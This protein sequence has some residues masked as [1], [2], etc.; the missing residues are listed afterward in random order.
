[1]TASYSTSPGWGTDRECDQIVLYENAKRAGA[2]IEF[3]TI[4][5]DISETTDGAS[6]M[7]STSRRIEADTL[8]LADGVASRLRS[9]FSGKVDVESF[10]PQ[11]GLDTAHQIIVSGTILVAN[12]KTKPLVDEPELNLW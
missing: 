11:F 3:E 4:V 5:E 6:I 9:R 12:E 2:T 10:V 8:L 7:L 1:M